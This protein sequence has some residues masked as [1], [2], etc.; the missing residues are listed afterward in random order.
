MMTNG[1]AETFDVLVIGGGNAALSAAITAAARGARVLL[2]EAA[3]KFYRGGNTRHT[4]NFRFAHEGSSGTVTGPY[5]H[6]E[7]WTDLERVTE[8]NTDEVLAHLTIEKSRELWDFLTSS[9]V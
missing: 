6:D 5:G 4:R 7:Y 8:G 1:D 3:P 2:V 9:G